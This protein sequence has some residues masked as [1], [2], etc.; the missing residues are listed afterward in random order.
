MPTPL[1][2]DGR[3]KLRCAGSAFP[4]QRLLAIDDAGLTES[5]QSLIDIAIDAVAKNRDTAGTLRS[6]RAE[7]PCEL[8]RD[9]EALGSHPH[10]EQCGIF[11]R[12]RVQRTH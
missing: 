10:M 11:R 6:R 3:T 2:R 9:T 7:R 1:L 12:C 8:L 5:A 4:Y